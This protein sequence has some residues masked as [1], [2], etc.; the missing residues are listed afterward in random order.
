[1]EELIFLRVGNNFRQARIYFFFFKVELKES[2][3]EPKKRFLEPRRK[4][5]LR[6]YKNNTKIKKIYSITISLL[7]KIILDEFLRSV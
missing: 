5:Y 2:F 1:M 6:F 4:I 7:M 3:F